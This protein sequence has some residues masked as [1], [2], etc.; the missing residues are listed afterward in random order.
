MKNTDKN[1]GCGK[2]VHTGAARPGDIV[3]EDN[4]RSHPDRVAENLRS[5]PASDIFV[6]AVRRAIYQGIV[7]Q[8]GSI[9]REAARQCELAIRQ[10]STQIAADLSSTISFSQED[11]VLNISIEMPE[12]MAERIVSETLKGMDRPATEEDAQTK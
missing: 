5:Q 8:V 3:R 10:M 4:Y 12:A 9:A 2:T 11:R 1:L 6:D 7:Q